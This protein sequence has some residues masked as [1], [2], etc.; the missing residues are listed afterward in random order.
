[1]SDLCKF[2]RFLRQ[3]NI[4]Q[5]YK[6]ELKGPT[7]MMTWRQIALRAKTKDL[8]GILNYSLNWSRVR[9]FDAPQKSRAWDVYI[10]SIHNRKKK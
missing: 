6:K 10:M 1:M 5:A 4:F 2:K 3:H 8:L 7:G 9:S